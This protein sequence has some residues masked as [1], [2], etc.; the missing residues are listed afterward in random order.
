MLEIRK[1]NLDWV[2]LRASGKLERSDY[3]KAVPKLEELLEAGETRWLVEMED[4]AGFTPAALVDELKFDWRHRNDF[5]RVA[6]IES[7]KAAGLGA[8]LIKPLFAGDIKV[9]ASDDRQA[10]ERWIRKN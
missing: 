5:E 7:S 3:E 4:F 8:R 6:I 2:T 9:F 10:A 1:D